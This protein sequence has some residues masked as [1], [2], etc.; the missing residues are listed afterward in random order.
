MDVLL[1]THFYEFATNSY[2]TLVS[3]VKSVTLCTLFDDLTKK[4]S[5]FV[6]QY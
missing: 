6:S 5:E 3:T 2:L 1:L 4:T